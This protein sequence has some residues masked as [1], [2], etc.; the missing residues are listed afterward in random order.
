MTDT[1]PHVFTANGPKVVDVNRHNRAAYRTSPMT[2]IPQRRIGLVRSTPFSYECGR[3]SRCCYHKGISLNPYEVLRLARNQGLTTTAFVRR[4]TDTA[5]TQLKQRKDGACVFMTADGCGVHTDRP[6]VCRIYPLG[7][8]IAPDGEETFSELEPHA[9][10]RGVYGSDATID[11][12]LSD[13]GAREFLDAADRYLNLFWHM[14]DQLFRQAA[15]LASLGHSAVGERC[16]LPDGGARPD[17]GGLD[18]DATLDRYCAEAGVTKPVETAQLL[19][20]HLEVLE[21]LSNT[22]D[23]PVEEKSL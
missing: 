20:M 3:C 17:A 6:L 9:E 5:G 12:Y 19:Q 23:N 16:V 2:Q 13:Q 15:H 21:S 18:I 11:D 10:T 8:H 1:R 14:S 4:Y 7:R 22:M